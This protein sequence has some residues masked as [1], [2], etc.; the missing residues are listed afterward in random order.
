MDFGISL[1]PSSVAQRHCLED[2]DEE[3]EDDIKSGGNEADIFTLPETCNLGPGVNIV[4]F[5]I[6]LP[7]SI[8]IKSYLNELIPSFKITTNF[9]TVFKDKFFTTSTPQT[10]DEVFE[11]QSKGEKSEEKFLVCVHKQQLTPQHCNLWCNSVSVCINFCKS[12]TNTNLGDVS[13]SSSSTHIDKL[14]VL[15]NS[16]FTKP[17]VAV[18]GRKPL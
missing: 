14:C 3:E 7:A 11:V 5:T 15:C 9:P 16:H 6:G 10:V 8:F 17:Y 13:S 1:D 4:I 18:T 12:A 2:S